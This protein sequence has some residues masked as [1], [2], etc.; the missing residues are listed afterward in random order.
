MSNSKITLKLV[1]SF[2]VGVTIH[3]PTLNGLSFEV[4]IACF[5]LSFWSRGGSRLFSVAN[6]WN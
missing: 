4:A 3:S 1:R 6:Y 2:S 5:V